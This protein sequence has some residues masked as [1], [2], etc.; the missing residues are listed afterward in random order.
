MTRTINSGPRSAGF[1]ISLATQL[2]LLI[3]LVTL[4]SAL[5]V[6]TYVRQQRISEAQNYLD[7]HTKVLSDRLSDY[8]TLLLSTYSFLYAD[9]Q[10][11][12]DISTFIGGLHLEQFF[13]SVHR[14]DILRFAEGQPLAV[15]QRLGMVD[16]TPTAQSLINQELQAAQQDGAV[17]VTTPFA[18][19]SG[20]TSGRLMMI[21]QPCT[22][23]EPNRS[24]P[25]VLYM[26]VDVEQLLAEI[27]QLTPA[28][29][30]EVNIL[31]DGQPLDPDQQGVFSAAS[32]SGEAT[33]GLDSVLPQPT[34]LN[35]SLP[36]LGHNWSLQAKVPQVSLGDPATL[37]A[38][39][40]L[41]MGLLAGLLTYRLVSE[42]LRMNRRLQQVNQD[43][44]ASQSFLQQSQADFLAIFHSVDG[45]VVFTTPDGFIR[46]TNHRI[47]TMLGLS[48][49][50]LAGMHIDALRER[51]VVN[52]P[53]NREA[54]FSAD[55]PEEYEGV[56]RRISGPAGCTFWGEL[57]RSR[58]VGQGQKLLGYLQVVRDVSETREAQQRLHDQEQQSRA[59]L[60][61]VPH[62][63]WLSDSAG[64][65][66]YTNQQFRTL[67]S[68]NAVREQLHPADRAGYDRLWAQ[69][70][71]TGQ[72][73]EG[74]FRLALR[75]PEAAFLHAGQASAPAPGWRWVSLKVAPLH[76]ASGELT[77]WIA[78][79][80]D[81][82]ARLLAEQRALAEQ[83]HYRLVLSGMPQL[84]WTVDAKWNVTYVNDRWY[85]LQPGLPAPI[86][87]ED[88]ASPVHP[89]DLDEFHRAVASAR[90]SLHP[91]EVE[92]QMV[93]PYG[94]YRTYVVRAVP[95]ADSSGA[96]TEWVGTTTDVD[97]QVRAE[98][99]ARM[100]VQVSDALSPQ[101]QGNDGLL[102]QQ[103]S[104]QEAVEL[105]AE[106]LGM[107]A[108]LWRIDGAS[109][110]TP[111]VIWLGQSFL[112]KLDMSAEMLEVVEELVLQAAQRRE[113]FV[114]RD[115]PLLK[116]LG[117][118]EFLY[119]PL[120]GH[121]GSLRGILG[122]ASLR[123]IHSHDYQL[124]G[125][126]AQRFALALDNDLL[127]ERARQAQE[128]LQLLNRSLEQRV[129]E[130]TRELDEAN[131]E[132]EAFSYSV[133]H[134]LRTPLRHMTGFS[135][136]LRK[137]LMGEQSELSKQSERY[138]SVILDSGQ[139]MGHLIDDLLEFS[140]TG[141]AELR[142]QEID[143]GRLISRV[144]D[145]LQPDREGR[146][147]ALQ[148]E[149][150]PPV[151]GDERLLAQ[152][153]ANLLGN[154]LK[155]SRTKENVLIRVDGEEVTGRLLAVRVH[156]NGAGF[157]PRYTDKLFGVFQ[158]LHSNDEFEGTGIGLANVRRIILRHGGQVA[159]EG[160]L[161]VGATFTVSL[162]LDPQ[163]DPPSKWP[164]A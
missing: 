156:D 97:D 53:N 68:G 132:L 99:S 57:S 140:R 50:A 136:L 94:L 74:D 148:L 63:L 126:L 118:T 42:Q 104:Y 26:L 66:T 60:D 98:F 155:Y 6:H 30:S 117:A 102:G 36:R 47:V 19:Q 13:P 86:D 11:G 5:A 28:V 146:R 22:P 96:V 85:E 27:E 37:L 81:V 89:D 8:E 91:L 48:E 31:L 162:P 154:A 107:S 24:L 149:A 138:L 9:K 1:R 34:M 111:K 119:L 39:L 157:D 54:L 44:G 113:T 125:Q 83:A 141:R 10:P 64:E 14:L 114:D 32:V 52:E 80:T 4:I 82:H 124:A 116:Q 159:A 59:A 153:F 3:V 161:G 21:V 23:R 79:A 46:L 33:R 51:V 152:V 151:Y 150:L 142:Q 56:V 121:S 120:L 2:L 69:A 110:P 38:P 12:T 130:R 16:L 72:G 62:V 58:V 145:D 29:S 163:A 144:W 143:L 75:T 115:S 73:Q 43:L 90:R 76:D 147:V 71:A 17:H 133:S 20:L 15:P 164:R 112:D 87:L 122:L 45:G 41:M 127:R 84:V 123:P 92:V 67:L 105:L 135:E 100:L 131:R 55:S 160:E 65:L 78:V 139:R 158:R 128:D 134:D 129:Q 77:D 49:T 40:V 88:L 93:G 103:R 25:C 106:S 95:L 137:K 35:T 101:P 7:S 18:A 70:Y 108:A 109:G 61:G